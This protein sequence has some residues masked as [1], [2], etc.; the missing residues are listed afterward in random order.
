MLVKKISRVIVSVPFLLIFHLSLTAQETQITDSRGT[1][2]PQNLLNSISINL[3]N[4]PFREAL[5][6]I[7]RQGNFYINYNEDIIPKNKN[8]TLRYNNIPI[9][10]AL[11]KIIK[12]A[13]LD[14]IISKGGE[15]V[16]VPTLPK[17]TAERIPSYT[18][19]GH[20]TNKKSGELLVGTNIYIEELQSGTSSNAYAFYSLTVPTGYYKMKYSYIGFKPEEVEINLDRNITQNIELEEI[21]F[22]T[23]TLVVIGNLE[24]NNLTSTQMGAVQLDPEKISG[25]PILLGEKDILKTIH[26]LPGVT[27]SREGNSGFF[28]RGGNSDQNLILLDEAPVYSAFHFM[29]FFSVFNS[30]AI[31]N[32][33]LIKGAA[34]AKYGGRLSSVLDIQMNEGNQKEFNGSA[35]IGLIFSRLTL[36]GPILNK[37]G[38]FLISGRRTYL[39]IFKIFTSNEDIKNSI[40][41]FYDLNLKTNYTIN[42]DDRIYLSGY[43]GRDGLGFS[44]RVEVIRGNTTATLR[45][46]HLFSDKIFSNSS[47]IYSSFVFQTGVIGEDE[48]DDDVDI[49][50]K[51]NDLTFKEDFEYFINTNNT[52]NFGVSYIYH[53]FLATHASIRGDN[54]IDMTIGKRNA[55]EGAIYISHEYK[56]TDR[57]NIYYGLRYSLFFV[58]GDADFYNFAEFPE[59]ID[60]AFHKVERKFYDGLEPRITVTYMLDDSS[61]VKA[62]YARNAQYIYMLSTP[63][64]GTPFDTWRPSSS[65]VKPQQSDQFSLGYFTNVQNNSYE[66][67]VELFYKNLYNLVDYR[68]GANLVLMNYFESELTFGKGWAYGA[69]FLL[70]KKIGKLTGWIGYSISKSERKFDNINDGRP[71]PAKYDRTHDFSIVLN[72]KLNSNWDFSANW[73]YSTGYTTTIPYGKYVVDN[74]T[75]NAYTDRNGF[76]MPPYHRLDLGISYSNESGGVWNF[77]IYN[78]YAR[79]N[80]YGIIFKR[81]DLNP[82]DLQAIKLA[83]FSI[84]PSISYTFKF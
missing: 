30:D 77:S 47:L 36:Q 80:A 84:V 17:T 41:Y 37:R 46:N 64:S 43:I 67:S 21:G 24:N 75:L 31:K 11:K 52:L 4:V 44:P 18:I 15:I 69:E 83:I 76:R 62:G 12:E 49:D 71:F 2:V 13:N 68:D 14:F 74:V 28:V 82:S 81:N 65:K 63:N 50:T 73:I 35:G 70:R 66:I 57:L 9:V 8:I 23:D 58:T 7:A 48:N 26:L 6:Q 79:R 54:D 40:L 3:K 61:S 32:A 19:S 72:Y 1:P 78:V 45:W 39:D 53:S 29:G 5:N 56:L 51:I 20:I 10:H 27:Y 60:F 59:D 38:S 22:V 34:P 55:H 16:L 25:I 33:V 42:K